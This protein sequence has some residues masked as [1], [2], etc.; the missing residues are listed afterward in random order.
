MDVYDKSATLSARN[1]TT[2][3]ST[4]FSLASRFFDSQTRQHIYNIYGLVRIADE[5]VDTY[6][7][8]DMAVLL[9]ELEAEV[10]AAMERQYSSNVIVH[11]FT[12]T[13]IEKD[14]DKTLV[15]PFFA[16]MR[17]DIERK[18]YTQKQYEAYIYGSAEVI[19]LMCL[20]VFVGS[21]KYEQLREGAAALGSAFQKINFLRDMRDD[22]EERG[23]YY[24]PVDS[25]ETFSDKTK[26]RIVVDITHDLK[27]AQ[28]ALVHLPARARRAVSI[29]L[30]Y[31]R[32]LL[33]QLDHASAEEVK[34]KRMSVPSYKKLLL[35]VK[36][37]V[38]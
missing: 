26:Q 34:S 4:S 11:A 12:L 23:R 16:S 2:T 32:E 8:K 25:Y 14:I 24:F 3:F 21:E 18:A 27:L 35:T 31:Y 7:G 5:I 29:A 28:K 1:V 10:Y 19:G 30:A 9:D 38:R 13:A 36:E 37:V 6:Q 15:K 22:Y 33:E 20:K 17:T